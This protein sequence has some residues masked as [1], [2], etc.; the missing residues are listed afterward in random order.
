MKKVYSVKEPFYNLLNSN[1]KLCEMFA[2][3]NEKQSKYIFEIND[4]ENFIDKCNRFFGEEIKLNVNE[5]SY[6]HPLKKIEYKIIYYSNYYE[7]SDQSDNPF[8]EL[9][10]RIY[11][12]LII[13]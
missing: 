12:Y 6:Y 2:E 1:I 11:S 4:F 8:F 7:I 9:L 3:V 13:I 5:L 10:N